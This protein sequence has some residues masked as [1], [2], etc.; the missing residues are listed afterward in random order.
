MLL[1]RELWPYANNSSLRTAH[2]PVWTR[3]VAPTAWMERNSP[4]RCMSRCML[5]A[6]FC[7]LVTVAGAQTNDDANPPDNPS[8]V[9]PFNITLP[10]LELRG[11]T[12][13]MFAALLR[14]SGLSGGIAV[15]NQE[16]SQGPEFSV[17]VGAG[18][19]LDKALGQVAKSGTTSKWQVRDGLAILLPIGFVPPLLQVRI[20]RFEWDRAAPTVE[21]VARLRNLP[22]VSAEALKL[23]LKEAPFEG[24]MSQYCIRGDCSQ[25]PKPEQALEMEE[26]A[27]LF[28]VLN[29]IARAHAGS[30]WNY[31]EYR[32]DQDTRFSL[33]VLAE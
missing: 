2:F 3:A 16:C 26:D 32:R 12:P 17:S 25:K 31:S 14:E 29:H 19:T 6:A 15:S 24:G 7:L 21:A 22:E 33:G 28:T 27:T 1:L 30:I 11:T 10:E 8:G 9:R 18:T 4:S 20:R 5:R 13:T 23:G